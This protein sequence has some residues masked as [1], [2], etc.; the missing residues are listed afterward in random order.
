MESLLRF[1]EWNEF[2]KEL[3][4]KNQ[5]K[6]ERKKKLTDFER[7]LIKSSDPHQ[8]SSLTSTRDIMG[9]EHVTFFTRFI[10]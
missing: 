2:I 1:K 3:S 4:N 10:V 9:P 7:I 6:K 8:T 5:K